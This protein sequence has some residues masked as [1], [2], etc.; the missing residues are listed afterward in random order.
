MGS[1]LSG[2]DSNW[3]KEVAAGLKNLP[4]G[5]PPRFQSPADRK[6]TS[7]PTSCGEQQ[8]HRR[9]LFHPRW[10]ERQRDLDGHGCE[11]SVDVGGGQ[12]ERQRSRCVGR[13]R[14]C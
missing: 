6:L 11:G 5:P 7:R 8:R 1:T 13:E 3:A 9:R 4:A 2:S 10:S 12:D 14:E